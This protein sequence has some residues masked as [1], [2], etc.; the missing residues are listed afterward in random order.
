MRKDHLNVHVFQNKNLCRLKSDRL[1][2][3]QLRLSEDHT[4]WRILSE[5][6]KEGTGFISEKT[7]T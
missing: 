2:F 3:F 4:I 5:K 6:K 1:F 7:E